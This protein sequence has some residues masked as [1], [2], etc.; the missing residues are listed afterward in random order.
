MVKI[1]YYIS[2]SIYYFDIPKI[3]QFDNGQELKKALLLFL[4]EYNI[5]LINKC[6][7]NSQTQCLAN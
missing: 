2:L 6:I 5:K 1:I 3:L 4:E 7:W